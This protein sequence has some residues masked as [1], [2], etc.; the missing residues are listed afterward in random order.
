MCSLPRS[1]AIEL[2][3]SMMVSLLFAHSK[4]SAQ[5]LC[6]SAA[7]ASI[8][9]CSDL[10]LH[11]NIHAEQ[12][13][14]IPLKLNSQALVGFWVGGC[15]ELTWVFCKNRM[16]LMA[17]PSLQASCLACFLT[18]SL[19]L[20]SGD[21]ELTQ[22]FS[23]TTV[24]PNI[25]SPHYCLDSVLASQVTSVKTFLRLWSALWRLRNKE[26]TE[27]SPNLLQHLCWIF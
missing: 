25:L 22:L 20:S 3:P 11:V 9:P 8:S 21:R 10:H 6:P 27:A 16:L 26:G 1:V 2:H 19:I 12:R 7:P 4:S 23:K 17:E 18:L 24:L 15:W 14:Q 5:G 13:H